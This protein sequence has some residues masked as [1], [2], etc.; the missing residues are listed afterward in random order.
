VDN[1]KFLLVQKFIRNMLYFVTNIVWGAGIGQCYSAGLRARWSGVWVPAG[2][3]NFSLRHRIQTGSGTHPASNSVGTR[4]SFPGGKSS[5]PNHSHLAPR[6]RMLWD[7]PPLTQYAFMA[8]CSVKTQGQIYL[9]LT[10]SMLALP[11]KTL[12]LFENPRFAACLAN[13]L[14]LTFFFHCLLQSLSD[15][16]LP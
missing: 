6:S 15:L 8:W 14:D 12:H 2:A 13:P 7:I 9:Y 11:T 4:D 1:T 5:R 16:G 10:L 3:G